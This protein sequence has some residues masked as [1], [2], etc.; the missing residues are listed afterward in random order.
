MAD[1]FYTPDQDLKRSLRQFLSVMPK[2]FQFVWNVSRIGFVFWFVLLLSA[3]VIPAAVTYLQKVVVDEVVLVSGGDGSWTLVWFSAAAIFGLWIFNAIQGSISNLIEYYIVEHGELHAQKTYLQKANS[4]DIAF[5]ETPR[6][7]DLLTHAGNQASSIPWITCNLIGTI[8]QIIS[9]SAMAGLLIILHPLA[10]VVLFVTALPTLLVQYVAGRRFYQVDSEMMRLGRMRS[11][12][13]SLAI[14]R[15][16]AKELRL[17]SLKDFVLGRF[18]KYAKQVI[19][20]NMKVH[21]KITSLGQACDVLSLIGVAGIYTYAV[22]EA[23][24]GRASP[25]DLLLVFNATMQ[26]RQM[27]FGLVMTVGGSFQELLMATRYF[28]FLDTDPLTV[29]GSLTRLPPSEALPVPDSIRKGVEFRHVSFSYPENERTVLR[30][31]S[32]FIPAGS[33][34]AIVGQNGA[35]K[36]TV[37]KLL[38]RLYDP[39]EGEVLVDGENVKHFSLKEVRRM[40]SVVFQ[41]YVEYDL[42]VAENIAVGNIDLLDS[43]EEIIKVAKNSG[44]HRV[45]EKLPDGYDT[46]LGKEYEEGTNLSGG[47]WQHLAVTRAFASEAQVLVLDEPTAALDA[48]REHELYE[49]FSQAAKDQTVVFISHRF[50]TVRMA[51]LII[52]IEEGE[53]QEVGSHEEL[54]NMDGMYAKMFRTQADRYG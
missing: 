5:F 24:G 28:Q 10:I 6:F 8:G 42:T 2:S 9:L 48:L 53:V 46:M 51:D 27:L 36:T 29:Q 40:F 26:S 17:F 3:S 1:A 18:T 7:Y 52:V 15:A 31:L 20:A 41:D 33:R 49:R 19:D 34:V 13:Q 11:Y 43:S 32:F 50:S 47:E 35:G 21:I 16:V 25:G 30:D 44:F 22:I 23:V 4:L 37:I 45:V 54:L 12:A 38:T 14:H 39:V